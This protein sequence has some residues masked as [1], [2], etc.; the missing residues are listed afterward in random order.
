MRHIPGFP[1]RTYSPGFARWSTKVRMEEMLAGE[2]PYAYC[3]NNPTTYADPSGLRQQTYQ[4]LLNRF[5]QQMTDEVRSYLPC[6]DVQPW[7]SGGSWTDMWG[8][9]NMWGYGNCCGFVRKCGPGSSTKDCVDKA[10]KEHDICVGPSWV[11]GIIN[12]LGC[13][14]RLGNDIKYCWNQHC[15]WPISKIDYDQ[16]LAIHDISTFMCNSFGGPTPPMG[17]RWK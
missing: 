5:Y 1:P 12:W 3:G 16:C 13:N 10:C 11:V 9:W 14:K 7:P 2:H 8:L 17:E 4:D 15:V 6:S